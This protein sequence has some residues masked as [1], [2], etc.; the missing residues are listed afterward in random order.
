MLC[1]NLCNSFQILLDKQIVAKS[2]ENVG[3]EMH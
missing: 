3:P 2:E 1:M